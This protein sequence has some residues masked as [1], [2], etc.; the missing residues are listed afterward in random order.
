MYLAFLPSME[1]APGLEME[2]NGEGPESH[3]TATLEP[4]LE[5]EENAGA[6]VLV[7]PFPSLPLELPP[8]V[9]AA[10]PNMFTTRFSV[11]HRAY[12]I[13]QHLQMEATSQEES[14]LSESQIYNIIGERWNTADESLKEP[15]LSHAEGELQKFVDQK[16]V[17]PAILHRKRHR[18]TKA[19]ILAAREQLALTP[20]SEKR[21]GRPPK[22]GSVPRPRVLKDKSN[23]G[24]NHGVSWQGVNGGKKANEH[25]MSPA[26]V[27]KN[28][29]GVLEGMFDAGYF[30][31]VRLENTDTVLRGVVFSPSVAVPL[32]AVND[33]VPG[34]RV[35]ER[36]PYPLPPLE[37]MAYR[38]PVI[39][40][41]ATGSQEAMQHVETL[42]EQ[43]IG[44]QTTQ[45]VAAQMDDEVVERVAQPGSI[46]TQPE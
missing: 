32:T 41:G 33:V 16:L 39:L 37:F 44:S 11:R 15:Y 8:S 30:I 18:R 4:D 46:P 14:G 45:G 21:R 17:D 9:P 7:T 13:F 40:P 5:Q 25:S 26:L 24:A 36:P 27:G 2:G 28:C 22:P 43:Q 42:A 31:S 29:T 23:A 38:S 19:E 10:Q 3:V 6:I 35:S 20:K 12:N 34:A 1:V